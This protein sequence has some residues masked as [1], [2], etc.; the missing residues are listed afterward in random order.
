MKRIRLSEYAKLMSVTRATA[1]NWYNKGKIPYPTERPSERIILV[2][3]PDDFDGTSVENKNETGNT[4]AYCRVSTHKQKDGLELQELAILKYANK[5]N[6]TID[7]TV[8]EVGSG[9]NENRPKLGSLLKNPK[10]DTIIVEH[11]DRLARSNFNLIRRCLEAQGRRIIVINDNDL[12]DDLVTEITEYMVS[13]CGKIYGR[14][15]AKRVKE[16]LSEVENND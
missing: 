3:V 9:F 13:V 1:L 7:K 11:R 8:K 12:E 6:I 16:A 14:R 10:V 15:G 2:Q 4:V 5:N